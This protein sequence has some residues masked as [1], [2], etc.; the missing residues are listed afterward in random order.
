MADLKF[1]CARCGQHISCDAAWSGH[2]IQCPVCQAQLVVPPAQPP[3]AG[4]VAAAASL[5]AHRPV[6]DGL[7]LSAG[8]TPVPPSTPP[9]SPQPRQR[10]AR[11]PKVAKSILKYTMIAVVLGVM[12]WAA[13][14]YLPALLSRA[15]EL[16]A[17]KVPASA[18]TPVGGGAGSGSGPLGE[19]NGAMDVSDAMEGNAPS[20]QPSTVAKP[21]AAAQPR[22]TSAT[23]SAV[24]SSR[25][26]QP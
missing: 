4:A 19:M 21:P 17:S 2:Q 23:N 25:S 8:P 18:A 11:S 26:R 3:L 15:Q 7:K 1:S 9:R 12:G 13:Y 14:A 5:A 24:K 22:A 16:G 20:K 6:P 10:L